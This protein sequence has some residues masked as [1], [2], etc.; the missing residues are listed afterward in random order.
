ML[1][2]VLEPV[3]VVGEMFMLV[4]C[5]KNDKGKGRGK[6]KGELVFWA[7]M[8]SYFYSDIG[9]KRENKHIEPEQILI[10]SS[11]IER[12][13]FWLFFFL[14]PS[15]STFPFSSSPSF[16]FRAFLSPRCPG[17]VLKV[18]F[19]FI[20]FFLRVHVKNDCRSRRYFTRNKL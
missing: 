14:K 1:G 7:C 2:L 10:Q 4:I 12:F 18:R 8:V 15:L 17:R 5:S 9:G 6:G 11:W 3:V 16:Y 20:F 13:F 19:A